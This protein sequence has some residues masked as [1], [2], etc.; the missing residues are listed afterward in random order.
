MLVT[1]SLPVSSKLILF[2]FSIQMDLGLLYNFLGQLACYASVQ[3]V[4]EILQ[5]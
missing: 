5:D 2:A 4:G 3:G 1:K